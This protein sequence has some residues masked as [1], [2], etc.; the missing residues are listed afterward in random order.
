MV[1]RRQG[2]RDA[3][4]GYSHQMGMTKP[5]PAHG[6]ESCLA[7]KRRAAAGSVL[8]SQ[9]ET[10]A[11]REP[12]SLPAQRRWVTLCRPWSSSPGSANPPPTLYDT[13]PAL[14]CPT[15][16][17]RLEH[18]RRSIPRQPAYLGSWQRLGM[19]DGIAAAGVSAEQSSAKG[20][21]LLT[22]SK[23]N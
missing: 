8:H 4:T 18:L 23:A 12:E 5:F 16:P 21:P 2:S 15:I 9:Q 19:V 10:G 7:A 14:H 1:K 6:L 11:R 13:N 22:K 3:C 17:V 20:C